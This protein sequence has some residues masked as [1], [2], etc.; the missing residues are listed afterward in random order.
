MQPKKWVTGAAA[1]SLAL[2]A[3]ACTSGGGTKSGGDTP[4]AGA[5]T[6]ASGQRAAGQSASTKSGGSVTVAR[7]L[8]VIDISPDGSFLRSSDSQIVNLI[9]DGLYRINKDDKIEPAL[10]ASE[11]TISADKLSW[12]IKLRSG[13]TFSD[14][15]PLSSADVKFSL[16]NAKKG[17]QQGKLFKA[18]TSIDAPDPSTVVIHTAAPNATLLWTLASFPAVILP[19]N[20]EGK[21]AKDFYRMPVGAGP[22]MISERKPG[23]DLKLVR[24][25]KYYGTPAKLDSITFVPVADPNTRVLKLRAGS[26]DLIED[27]PTQ[28]VGQLKGDSKFQVIS[29]PVGVMRLGLNTVKPPL[30]D[31]HFRRAVSLALDRDSMVKAVLGGGGSKACAWISATFLQGYQPAFGCK[32]DVAAAKAELA[33]S[34]TPTGASFSIVYDSADAQMPLTAQIIQSDLQ[35]IG[36]KVELNGTTNQLYKAALANKTFQGRFSL[37]ALAGDPGL[38]VNNYIATGAESTSSNLLPQITQEYQQSTSVFDDTARF[39]LYDQIMDQIAENG[40][41]VALYSPDKLWAASSKVVGASILPT[42]KLDFAD[43]SLTK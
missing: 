28:Q 5:N 4:S 6:T 41:A 19:N 32:Y 25:P 12:T 13:I 1:V 37:F 29:L 16:D 31:V 23:T 38:S 14:G 39:K 24:N 17:T 33:Q 10:A 35:K 3:T 36:V 30:N 43:I 26:V 42:N 21:Q 7:P 18:I 2:I 22:F 9:A 40:D 27:P 11:P 8:D 20:F 34:A 15:T